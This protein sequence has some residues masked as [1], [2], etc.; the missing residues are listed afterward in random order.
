MVIKRQKTYSILSKAANKA[1]DYTIKVRKHDIFDAKL[2][3]EKHR[4]RGGEAEAER[5]L[6]LYHKLT[7]PQP[8]FRI[9]KK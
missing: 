7:K 5:F 6:N 8:F 9:V 2:A 1:K 4:M 3:L